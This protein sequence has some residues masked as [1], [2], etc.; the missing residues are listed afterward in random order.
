MS[1]IGNLQLSAVI[2]ALAPGLPAFAGSYSAAVLLDNPVAY[3]RLDETTGATASNLGTGAGINGTYVNIPGVTVNNMSNYGQPG[4]R[5]A[6][7]PGFESGN[8]SAFFDPE[9]GSVAASTTFPRVEVV[10][11]NNPLTITGALTLEAWIKRS[12]QAVDGGNNEG[13]VGRFRQD[14]DPVTAGLQQARS[15]VLYFDSTTNPDNSTGTPGIGFALSSSGTFQSANNY[16]FAADIPEG[17]WTHVAAVFDPGRRV[18]VYVNGLSIGELIDDDVVDTAA[19]IQILSDPLFSGL[20]DFW[21][22]QQFTGADEWTF[23]GNIDE[24]A[25][26]A[27]A[28]SDAQILNHFQAAQV[29]EPKSWQLALLVGATVWLGRRKRA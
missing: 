19:D 20:A 27:S 22:G 26:Y 14:Q 6:A 7:F 10:A 21:I 4:P 18:E 24:V 2:L 29:P 12:A 1:R 17:K 11:P 15:Y 3:Y 16:E 25:V 9:N 23:E 5:P 13:I 28:L 8:N